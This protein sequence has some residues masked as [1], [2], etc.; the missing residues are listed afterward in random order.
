[1][2]IQKLKALTDKLSTIN[3]EIYDIVENSAALINSKKEKIKLEDQIEKIYKLEEQIGKIIIERNNAITKLCRDEKKA[4]ADCESELAEANL[5]GNYNISCL[6]PILTDIAKKIELKEFDYKIYGYLN[7]AGIIVENHIIYYYFEVLGIATDNYPLL[8]LEILE[9][10]SNSSFWPYIIAESPKPTEIGLQCEKVTYANRSKFSKT[11]Q[12]ANYDIKEGTFKFVEI[13][14]NVINNTPSY[15]K[16][17][18]SYASNYR[19]EHDLKEISIDELKE[20]ENKFLE[21][22]RDKYKE[23]T[24]NLKK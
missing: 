18:I 2:N 9:H 17:F 3:K 12:F 24:R 22:N 11:H 4:W 19:L 23:Q 20:L 8:P 6:M 10:T 14:S 1:M 7:P 21:E 13:S 15:I 5:Y 16:D